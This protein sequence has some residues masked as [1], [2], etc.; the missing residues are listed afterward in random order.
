[1]SN[2]RSQTEKSIFDFVKK[3]SHADINIVTSDTMLFREGV[4]DS[5]GFVLLIDYLEEEF[6]IKSEDNDLT[7]ENFESINA[8]V[9]F[10]QR[11]RK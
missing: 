5:M 10:V 6:G 2:D 3:N 11:K 7:E 8:I 9:S 1:M 4:F